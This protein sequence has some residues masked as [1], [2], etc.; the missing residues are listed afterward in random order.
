MG[1]QSQAGQV[2]FKTQAAAGTYADPGAAAPDNGVFM[3]LRSGS[4]GPARDL[5][6]PDPEIGGGRDVPDAYLGAVA[7]SGDYDF[8]ART[9]SIAT[10]LRGVFGAATSAEIMEGTAGS[11]AHRHTITPVDDAALPWLSV[12]EAIAG[13]FDVFNYTDAK[14][15]TF[16][17][18]SD[19]NGY[20]MGT[21]GMIARLQT[22]GNVR[23]AAPSWDTQPMLVGTNVAVSLGGIALPA[24]TFSFDITNNIEDD[25]FRLGSFYLGDVPEKR[26]EVTAGLTVRP[27]DS[28]F[29]RQAVYGTAGATAPGGLV[30][31]EQLII[32]A[33]T[34]ELAGG[35]TTERHTIEITIPYVTIEPFEVEPSGDDIIEHDLSLR[36]LRPDPAADIATVEVVNERA[37]IA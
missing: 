2:G 24:K 18:E 31:K 30:T 14:V 8:Y 26:R 33:E 36:A 27:E 1:F 29:W 22:A 5:L 9:D 11:G 34:Y 7:F 6:V 19:A 25:D 3:R 12:E 4:L 13:G 21:A 37:A 16:H 35:S 10:L 17:L 23:T 32:T 15:N 28:G 20:L